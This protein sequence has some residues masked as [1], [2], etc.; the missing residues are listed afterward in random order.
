MTNM[1]L[2]IS[3]VKPEEAEQYMRIRHETFRTTVNKI[4][5]PLGEP[6]QKTLDE[7]TSSIRDG[8]VNKGILFI[9]CVDSA[10]GEF[11]AA[12]RWRYVKPQDPN[13]EELTWGEVD[14]AFAEPLPT[15]DES[16][17]AM[18]EEFHDTFN[19]KKREV[20]GTR[21]YYVLDTLVTYKQH[22][23]KGAGSALVRWGCQKADE[24]GVATYLEASPMG[25]PMYA[26]HGFEPAGKMELDLRKY[27][28][29][30]VLRFIVSGAGRTFMTQLLTI[31]SQC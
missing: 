18:L 31:A 9:K 15:F 27:G 10:T 20:L 13:A 25:E 21:P 30:E 16:I 4:H 28:V 8:I 24:A 17:P 11:L 14:A 3:M 19:D 23:R 12:A 1:Q 6:S 26:R 5:Y 2:E 22:E 29:D 7:V